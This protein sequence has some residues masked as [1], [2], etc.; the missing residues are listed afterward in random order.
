MSWAQ[1]AKRIPQIQKYVGC[2]DYRVVQVEDDTYARGRGN[3]E[4]GGGSQRQR[5]VLMVGSGETETAA[6]TS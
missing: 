6:V 5:G 4:D 1:E 2:E 3:W